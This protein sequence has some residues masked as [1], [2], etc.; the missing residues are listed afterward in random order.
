MKDEFGTIATKREMKQEGIRRLYNLHIL[1]PVIRDF[2]KGVLQKSETWDGLL[3]WLED[4]EKEIVKEFEEKTGCLV[5]HV[6]VTPATFGGEDTILYNLLYVS[7]YK[8]DWWAEEYDA[9][10]NIQKVYCVNTIRRECSEYGCIEIER[11]NGG[12]RRIG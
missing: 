10:Y 12:L 3:Y 6:I 1:E 9:I 8:E 2:K 5:Y 11:V 7:K 4:E